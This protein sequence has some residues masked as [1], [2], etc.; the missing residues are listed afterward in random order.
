MGETP[1]LTY[2]V[3]NLP[4]EGITLKGS[5]PFAA[6]DIDDD[7]RFSYPQPLFYELKLA[8]LGPDVIVTGKLH[9]VIRCICD[10]CD[11]PGELPVATDDV[12]HRYKNVIGKVLDLT[13]DI[14]EDILV[15][16]P[17]SYLCCESCQGLCPSCGQ[18]LNLGPCSCQ[19]E[20]DPRLAGLAK[21]LENKENQE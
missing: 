2:Q 20:I 10:R 17:Q 18:N 12:C 5:V 16:F 3:T 7:D 15:V 1:V 13:T 8:P 14:R 19:K 6:L 21:L 11:S 4:N 9:A